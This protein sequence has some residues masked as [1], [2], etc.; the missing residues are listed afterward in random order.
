M[1]KI[2][3]IRLAALS[4]SDLAEFKHEMQK[5]FQYGYECEFGPCPGPVLP[6]TD[7]DQTLA[8][9]GAVAYSAWV[10]NV[11][12]GGAVVKIDPEN[13]NNQLELFFIRTS[14]QGRGLG[15]AIWSEIEKL[16][17][18]T[19]IWETCTP[20]FEK[21]NLHFYINCLGFQIVEFFNPR[22]PFPEIYPEYHGGMSDE[23][24]KYFFRFRKIMH[25]GNG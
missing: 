23:A 11:M 9:N 17:P 12:A 16:Y 18:T 4:E 19:A 24:G 5:A 14:F 6:E 25:P 20:Y 2:N 22:H 8:E 10:D 15:R 7:I 13:Q 3:S 21:R 1:K